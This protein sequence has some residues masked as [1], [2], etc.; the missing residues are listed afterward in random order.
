VPVSG[1]SI[2]FLIDTSGSM[3]KPAA[4]GP[5]TGRR[6]RANDGSRLDA[7][8]EQLL[9]AAQAMAPNTQFQ[10]VTFADRARA[11]T[12][13]PIKSGPASVRSLTELLSR[14]RPHGATNLFDGLVQALQ[15][16]QRRHGDATLPRIDEL[17][18][19][20]DGEP[21]AGQVQARDDLLELVREANKYAKVRIHCVF[22]GNGNGH[23]LLRALAE[24]NGGVFVQR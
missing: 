5:T 19:L 10:V 22:T 15:L 6:G 24:Q 12:S 17:F 18:V 2:A 13:T 1:G 3:E 21:N 11:W 23:E 4:S 7:A 14:L 20:S 8:K 16:D 9:L